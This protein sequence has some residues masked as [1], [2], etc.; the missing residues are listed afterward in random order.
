[1]TAIGEGAAM[2]GFVPAADEMLKSGDP[3]GGHDEGDHRFVAARDIAGGR[4]LRRRAALAVVRWRQATPRFPWWVTS[5]TYH[6]HRAAGSRGYGAGVWPLAM[7]YRS[8]I[9]TCPVLLSAC[10][11]TFIPS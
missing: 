10:P 8:N 9:V 5:K 7:L 11:R 1:M 3:L 6:G 2:L 4:C